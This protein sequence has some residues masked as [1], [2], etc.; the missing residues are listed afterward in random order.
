MLSTLS[1]DAPMHSSLLYIPFWTS[2][3]LSTAAAFTSTSTTFAD[4]LLLHCTSC[5]VFWSWTQW[6]NMLW[7]WSFK[8][9]FCFVVSHNLS[10]PFCHLVV[11]LSCSSTY[12][13]AKAISQAT[14]EVN[15]FSDNFFQL[16]HLSIY[17]EIHQTELYLARILYHLIVYL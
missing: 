1:S 6:K 7:Q 2:H 14:L 13:M 9:A 8:K 3:F 11:F 15:P 10:I 16:I 17:L 12:F 5:E 4:L